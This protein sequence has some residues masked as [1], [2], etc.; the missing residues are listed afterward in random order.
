MKVLVTGHEGYIGCVLVP[1][2]QSAGHEVV[3]LDNGLFRGCD[4]DPPVLDCETLTLDI[5][6]VEPKHLQ[7]FDAV[8][9]L[10]GISNDPLGDLNPRGT[11]DINHEASVQVARAAKAAGVPRFIHSSSCSLY[12]AAG[13]A[14]IDET[15]A[16][17]PVT[18]YGESK[19]FVER[20]V[21]PMA[22]DSFSPTF[23]RNSTAYGVSPR[24][25]GDLVVNNLT[26]YALTTGE[27]LL[28]SD[29]TPWRP[30]V[31]IRDISR[32]FLAV[33]EADRSLVHGKAYNVGATKE[34]YQ[35]IDVARIVADV[36]PDSHIKI[37]EG[38]GPDKRCYRVDCDLITRELGFE[39][40]WTVRQG[41]EELYEAYKAHG[42]TLDE[43][44]SSRYVRIRH[45]KSLIDG[46]QIDTNLRFKERGVA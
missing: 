3:G 13:D 42:L 28:K 41:V 9:H 11:Y 21:T 4:F 18:P 39:C 10:A 35:M 17:N 44:T 32:A 20:D 37:E 36:V 25:R 26:G 31:H 38:A 8:V 45:V 46:G 12:G 34:N 7:G 27:V 43:F 40:E 30:L 15:G 19:V 22:D 23:L 14:P 33:M 16:F 6:D 24:L 2:F 29:G 5:R 1:L